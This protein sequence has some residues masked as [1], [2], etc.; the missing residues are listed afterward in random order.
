MKRQEKTI[1]FQHTKQ[2]SDP[3]SYM[4]ISISNIVKGVIENADS[5]QD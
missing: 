2:S 5:M 1:Y 4:T 3:D